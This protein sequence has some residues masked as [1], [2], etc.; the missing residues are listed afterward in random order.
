[1][2][3]PVSPL[4]TRR[5]DVVAPGT[6]VPTQGRVRTPKS[7]EE[8]GGGARA[9]W[10]IKSALALA[11]LMGVVG[12]TEFEEPTPVAPSVGEY[13]FRLSTDE[14]FYER[15]IQT[16]A[17]ALKEADLKVSPIGAEIMAQGKAL[18]GLIDLSR[19]LKHP[20]GVVEVPRGLYEE[21]DSFARNQT[22]ERLPW[23]L[24]FLEARVE[25]GLFNPELRTHRAIMKDYLEYRRRGLAAAAGQGSESSGAYVVGDGACSYWDGEDGGNSPEDCGPPSQSVEGE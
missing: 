7:A 16:F 24:R 9:R 3:V 21:V 19:P 11:S 14:E 25:F 6:A 13:S 2:N 17:E 18:V 12:C 20:N 4:Y 23:A 15:R 10:L 1:M 5:G 8:R 22:D